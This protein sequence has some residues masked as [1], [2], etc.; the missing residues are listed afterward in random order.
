MARRRRVRERQ[1]DMQRD[2]AGLRA[3]TG[4]R[5]HENQGG[6]ERLRVVRADRLERVV[7]LGPCKHAEGEQQGQRAE[8]RHDQIDVAGAG[9]FRRG[10]V[11]HH[12]RPGRQRHE[13][14]G[15]QKRKGVIR[16]HDQVHAG[17]IGRKIW[18]HPQ[19]S[20][21]V[22][23]IAEGV[24]ACQRTAQVGNDEKECRQRIQA[25]V[26]TQ[27]GQ[28]DRQGQD[29]RRGAG[30]QLPQPRAKPPERGQQACAVDQGGAEGRPGDRDGYGCN[31][32]QPGHAP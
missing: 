1:P 21:L 10:V 20:G 25:K 28:A 23:A 17:E 9:I 14:P 29:R 13:L 5:Q 6:R 16:Q 12:Q 11:G 22:P 24:E 30:Q 32:E 3:R 18:Q 8:G 27:P 19:W 4:E 7:A 15:H 31:G 26:R 2:E